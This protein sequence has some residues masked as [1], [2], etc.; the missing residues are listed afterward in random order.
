MAT[1]R[2]RSH[3]TDLH[4]RRSMSRFKCRSGQKK[5]FDTSVSGGERVHMIG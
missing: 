1:M 4:F 3:H 2:H 5:D